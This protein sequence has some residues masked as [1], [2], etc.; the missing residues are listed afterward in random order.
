M[1]RP[2]LVY[3]VTHP[4]TADLLLRGQL[5]FMRERGFDVTVV[6]APGELLDKVAAREGVEVV[7][8]PME[9]ST[10]LGGDLVAVARLTQLFRRIR[11]DIV[12]AGTTKG[13]L[14][15]MMAARAASVP[16]RI[17]LLRGLRLET[18]TGPMRAILGVTERIAS[19]CA[20]DVACVSRSLLRLSTEGG[21][22]PHKKALVI[23]EGSSNGVDTARFARTE[24][25]RAEGA[26]RAALFGIGPEDRVVGFVGRLV[27][28]KGVRELLDAFAIVRRE[29]PRAKLLL[30][31]SDL[32]DQA[33]DPELARAVRDAPGV[34][35]TGHIADVAPFYARMDVLAFPSFRE[36]FP[37]T[38]LEAAS[39]SLPVVAFRST[40]IVDAVVEGETGTIVDQ[41][42]SEALGR[43]IVAYLGSPELSRAHGDAA[44]A[45]AT[46]VFS[47]DAVW[48]AWLAH[49]RTRLAARGL[50]EP[51]P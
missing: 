12:N 21:W 45:R 10:E 43:G 46:R 40:G 44:R 33:I 9:R 22:I 16:V 15:G 47:R 32:G 49:Y 27:A 38:L 3:V 14:L 4:V 18:V 6:A 5:S 34:V 7:A 24:E 37:N 35:P 8:I 42:D 51:A 19:A 25:L 26:R 30:V 23:G 50:P 1:R 2:R 36:G 48:G 28:D 29:V 17:Y 20:H 11:P 13:G 31:G 41:R 39:A